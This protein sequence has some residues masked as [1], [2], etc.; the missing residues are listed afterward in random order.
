MTFSNSGMK[1]LIRKGGDIKPEYLVIV[2]KQLDK[3]FKDL[4]FENGRLFLS[5]HNGRADASEVYDRVGF[6]A[7]YNEIL[8]NRLFPK[9]NVT[10]ALAVLFH[11][12]FITRLAQEYPYKFCAVLS[13]DNGR[14]TFR[15]HIVREGEPLWISEDIEKFSQP[16]LY[17]IIDNEKREG[18][19]KSG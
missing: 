3:L 10:S 16:V 12:M 18:D 19:E 11:S 7:C 4:K 6:E 2:D 9:K 17:D 5:T 13:E 14:W 8:I 1:R 15:F